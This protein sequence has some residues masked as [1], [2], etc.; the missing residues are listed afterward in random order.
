MAIAIS[1]LYPEL[2]VELPGIVEPVLDAAVFRGLRKF[3]WESEAWKYT[4]DNGLDYTISQQA[5]NLPVAG[6]D[7]PAKTVVKRVDNVKW[8]SDGADWDTPVPFMTRDQLDRADSDWYTETGTKPL[9]WT[10]DNGVPI[11]YPIASA[12]VTDGLLLRVVIAPVYTAG[13]DTLPDLLYYEF[14]DTI[15][16]GILADLMKMPGKDW[17]DTQMASYYKEQYRRGV[18]MAKSRAEAD[19]GQP[20]RTMAYGGL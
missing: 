4:C 16:A 3:F 13:A 11:V 9:A 2:R 10:Y 7:I 12:T 14:E 19:F 18:N 5:M 8:D 6:T 17:T 1:T 20:D 15:K